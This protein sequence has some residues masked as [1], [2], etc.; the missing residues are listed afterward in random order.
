[1][2]SAGAIDVDTRLRLI[3]LI[4]EEDEALRRVFRVYEQNKDVYHLI[5]N[6]K[7]RAFEESP[8]DDEEVDVEEEEDDVEESGGEGL[9]DDDEREA[10][11]TRFLNIIQT[12]N[13][14]HLETAALRLSIARDDPAIRAA[15]ETFRSYR[16]TESLKNALRDVAK[17]TIAENLPVEEQ[18][19]DDDDDDNGGDEEDE[20]KEEED[21][22]E[23]EA[24]VM[25][26][27]SARDR[28]FP[29]LIGELTKED[30]LSSSEGQLLT[31]L[32]EKGDD[33]INAALDVYDLD[34]DMAELADTMQRVVQA[35]DGE[36]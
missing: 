35:N 3:E 28:I 21:A 12:M 22:D 26:T 4:E 20:D 32:F 25:S 6:L 29:I 8:D 10:I 31:D 15:L 7:R 23:T 16:N 19:D 36:Q 30:V 13:L 33:V 18:G 17:S 14:S 11:E 27:Q 9:D 24:G 5:E 2:C 34:N 1:V